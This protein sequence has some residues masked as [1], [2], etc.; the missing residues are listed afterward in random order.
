MRCKF[1]SV[2]FSFASRSDSFW[3]K[4]AC[5][6]FWWTSKRRL[7]SSASCRLQLRVKYAYNKDGDL[8]LDTIPLRLPVFKLLL[9]VAE[10][11]AVFLDRL[12]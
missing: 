10:P 5:M 3:S 8:I 4:P 7:L 9:D 2:S 11:F 1:A 6:S 12:F